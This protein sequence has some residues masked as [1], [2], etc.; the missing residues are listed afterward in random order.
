MFTS[1]RVMARSGFGPHAGR[2]YL[3]IFCLSSCQV[4]FVDLA[5]TRY[6]A[7]MSA[8]VKTVGGEVALAASLVFR[9]ATGSLRSTSTSFRCV[10]ADARADASDMAG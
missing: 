9:S 7:A 8:K 4:F 5:N 10:R 1:S 6:S 2:R 3:L